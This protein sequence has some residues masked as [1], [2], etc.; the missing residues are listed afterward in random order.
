MLTSKPPFQSSTTDEIYRRARER[1]YEWPAE[2]TKYITQEAKDLVSTMLEVATLRPD[3]DSIVQDPFF[4]TGYMP[5]PSDMTSKLRERA[6]GDVKYYD[7]AVTREQQAQNF[8]TLQEMCRDCGVG[9]WNDTKLIHKPVWKDVAAEESAGLTPVIPLAVGQVYRPFDDWLREN[10]LQTRFEAR[11]VPQP[12]ERLSQATP[13]SEDSGSSS[14]RVPSGLLRA[15]PQSFAAQQ[16]AQHRPESAVTKAAHTIQ[17]TQSVQAKETVTAQTSSAARMRIKREIPLGAALSLEGREQATKGTTTRSLRGHVPRSRTLPAAKES[18]PAPTKV[19]AAKPGLAKPAKTSTEVVKV[20]RK[21]SSSEERLSLFSPLE[22]QEKVPGSGPDVVLCRLRTLQSELERA[23]NSRSMAIVSARDK[24]PPTPPIVVKWVDH[25][26][27]FGMG[28]ILND[29]S[30]G[31]ILI[32]T[33]DGS[34]QEMLPSA[35]LH[36]HHAE[37]H[38]L[39]LFVLSFSVWLLF[40]PLLVG[41]FI[42]ENLGEEGSGRD[43]NETQSFRVSLDATGTAKLPPAQDVYDRRKRER[44][45]VLRKFANYM[46]ANG[47]EGSSSTDDSPITV[48]TLTDPTAAPTD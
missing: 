4:V 20:A 35:G 34:S 22:Y 44:V 25:S 23:L 24:T 16:R 37:R 7:Y 6:P 11:A 31:C 13:V 29:G 32:P 28:Y 3:P 10:Q 21:V 40:L 43:H 41:F 47:R 27:R 36:V 42:Y 26:N 46:L 8:Q 1:D 5:T 15:P 17:A 48:P 30:V 12:V 19:E 38:I 33:S 45:V 14:H 2:E 18:Q 9:P 39:R